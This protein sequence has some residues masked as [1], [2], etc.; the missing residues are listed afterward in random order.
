MKKNLIITMSLILVSCV[1][2]YAQTLKIDVRGIEKVTGALNVAL[3]DSSEN[4]L[5]KPV[6]AFR[7]DVSDTNLVLSCP[8]LP[9][10]TYAIS[11]YQDENKNNKLDTGMFGIPVEK[12][13]FSNDAMGYAGPPSFKECKFV[14]DKDMT[15]VINLK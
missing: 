10:G 11:M 4:F 8:G 6:A 2:T 13:G 7:V 9:T 12:Y 1:T 3:Y 14:F 5:K 15:T